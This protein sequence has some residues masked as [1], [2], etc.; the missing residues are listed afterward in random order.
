MI[1]PH[2]E[3]VWRKSTFSQGA[4]NSDCVEV[5]F[6]SDRTAIRDSKNPDGGMLTLPSQ[7][8]DSFRTAIAG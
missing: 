5:G 3:W 6:G 1:N 7:V 2:G 4:E 8:W